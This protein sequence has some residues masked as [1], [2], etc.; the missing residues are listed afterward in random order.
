VSTVFSVIVEDFQQALL[1]LKDIVEDGQT[2]KS[3]MLARVA[4]VNATTLL[5]A[6][7]FEEFIRQM[8][9]ECVIQTVQKASSIDDLP[10]DL[11]E[12]AW[13]RTFHV[14]TH[15]N[16]S[17]GVSK[18]EAL[19]ISAKKARPTIEALCNFI[20]G[21]INQDVFENLI[22]NENGMGFKEINKLF[23]V[24]GVSNI[25]ME[26]CKNE[27]LRAFFEVDDEK[28]THA[29][30]LSA[31]KEFFERR[32]QIA[33]SLNSKNSASPEQILRDI[34]MFVALASDLGRT[35]EVK[36]AERRPARPKCFDAE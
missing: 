17:D 12:T 6:A 2:N 36:I 11:L 26:I 24:G 29:A 1:P 10:D 18:K 22:H 3:S 31:L 8:A 27:T 9:R 23:K 34:C 13:R 25:C 7:T 32:N 5:L 28:A 35:L 20:E 15:S 33:H 30:L 14:L 4:S 16:K 19:R 21:D